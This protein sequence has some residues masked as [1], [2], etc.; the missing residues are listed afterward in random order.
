M[1][2]KDIIKKTKTF[3]K[4]KWLSIISVMAIIWAVEFMVSILLKTNNTMALFV[5]S[6]K[7]MDL[8]VTPEYIM[9]MARFT[10]GGSFAILVSSFISSAMNAGFLMALLNSI[11]MNA[12]LRFENVVDMIR[13]HFIDI[14]IIS[15]VS[16]LIFSLLLLLP[17]IGLF[18]QI[19]VSYM[20]AFA[21]FILK[22]G[23]AKDGR[24]AIIKSV[25]E[26]KGYKMDLLQ[27]NLNYYIRPWI[28]YLIIFVGVFFLETAPIIALGLLILGLLVSAWLYVLYI[29][30]AHAATAIFYE[31]VKTR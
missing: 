13:H 20:F 31:N 22:D 11:Q 12:K 26:T 16:S 28:G 23:R 27:L 21:Y 24:E 4:G 8:E 25:D 17:I 3:M 5:E 9:Y 6:Y 19:V 15:V 2:R 29:P 1:D 18:L 30:Y 14:L 7:L 10:T